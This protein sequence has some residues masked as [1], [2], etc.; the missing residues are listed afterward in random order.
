MLLARCD[1]VIHQSSSA[2]CAVCSQHQQSCAHPSQLSCWRELV[3]RA[4]LRT[5]LCLL[6]RGFLCVVAAAA[7]AA[8]A[9][10][11]SACGADVQTVGDER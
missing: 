3:L 9:V 8:A 10:G 4:L 6:L 5:A 7:A 1:A 2:P 11:V